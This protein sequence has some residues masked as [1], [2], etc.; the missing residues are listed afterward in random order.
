MPMSD[1]AGQAAAEM[2]ARSHLLLQAAETINSSLDSPALE[3][4]ILG[5]A[6]RLMGADAA[7]LLLVRG[8]VLVAGEVVGLSDRARD[9]FVVPLETS[10]YGRALVSGQVVVE[11]SGED[12]SALAPAG[13][14]APDGPWH[15]VLASPLSSNRTAYGALGLFFRRELNFGEEERA[16][17]RTFALQAAIALDNRRLMEE[18]ERMAVHDGLTDVYNRGYLEIAIDRVV[19]DLERHGGEVSVL[20]V[21]VDGMKDVNDTYGH[22]AGDALLVELARLLTASCRASDVVARYGGDEFVVLMSETDDA[23]AAAVSRKVTA[24]IAASNAAARPPHL[25][26]SIGTHTAGAGPAGTLLREAD[27]KMY[28]VKRTH[29]SRSGRS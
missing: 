19:K 21:D 18:K 7:A 11:R 26:V 29:A 8:D 22:E 27:R 28:A 10:V 16:L 1:A 23:G 3:Q 14:T 4:T 20:F 17:L 2:L 6:T 15:T 25:R 5:E 24:A 9:G 12:A 13:V